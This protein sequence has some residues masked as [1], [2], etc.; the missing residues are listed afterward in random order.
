MG[1]Q[2]DHQQ[3][4]ADEEEVGRR[5]LPYPHRHP[6]CRHAGADAHHYENTLPQ[7][8]VLTI[9]MGVACRFRNR[10]RGGIHHHQANRQQAHGE[11][12]QAEIEFGAGLGGTRS[13]Q[14]R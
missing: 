12:Q 8:I 1:D 10:D 11:P 9:V 4:Q 13:V 2:H 6:E 14:H 5:L 3:Q 7:Q